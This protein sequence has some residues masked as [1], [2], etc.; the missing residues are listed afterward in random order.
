[1]ETMEPP[2]LKGH[3]RIYLVSLCKRSYIHYSP[4]VLET[5]MQSFEGKCSCIHALLTL[6]GGEMISV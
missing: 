5:H 6:H 1:M 4:H 2:S 3:H